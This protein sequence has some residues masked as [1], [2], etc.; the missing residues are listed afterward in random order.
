[1]SILDYYRD[2]RD[3]SED[4]LKGLTTKVNLLVVLRLLSFVSAITLIIVFW[5]F[6]LLSVLSGLIGVSL[7]G[8]F[9]KIH[10]K[11]KEEQLY[12]KALLSFYQ[13]ELKGEEEHDW[14]FSGDGMKYQ[15]P[16]HDFSNDID[17]FGQRSFFQRVNKTSLKGGESLLA[18]MMLANDPSKV[19]LFQ[20][21]NAE[22]RSKKVFL[23][24]FIGYGRIH[25]S[26]ISPELAKTWLSEYNRFIPNWI[27]V[28]LIIFPSIS[29][30]MIF[31]LATGYVSGT[32]FSAWLIFGLAIIG[33][34][35]KRISHFG[36][37]ISQ[38][39]STLKSYGKLLEIIE[40]EEFKSNLLVK[41]KSKIETEG[42][43]ASMII[44]SLS[45]R[46][47]LFNNR[48]NLLV[49]ILG[50]GLLLWDLQTS[51]RLEKW[52]DEHAK[53]VIEWIDTIYEFDALNSLAIYANNHDKY[54]YPKLDDSVNIS[55]SD[56][57]H[58]LIK[59]GQCVLNNIDISPSSFFIITGANMAGKST[60][61][62]TISLAILMTNLGLPVCASE[63]RIRPQKLITSM[64][65]SDS[66]LEDESYFFAELKRLK[67]IIDKIE[68]E[69]YFIILDEI[70]KGTN[71]KDKEE[72]SR[73]FVSRLVSLKATGIIATHDLGLCEIEKEHS[74][75][76]NFYFDAEIV[77]DELH[78]DYKMKNGVCKN[79]NAS[80]LLR[81]M[82][83]V[84]N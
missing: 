74:E 72:G 31:G 46:I 7:F 76:K 66:L 10:L 63:I 25:Q 12:W 64:R 32:I 39:A 18:S 53:E 30:L 34:F 16:N 71:S 38:I 22:L 35:V 60:F 79:M 26:D 82:K 45:R 50:N 4:T 75:V 5:K 51:F 68:K 48:N 2:R 55:A 81:K 77:D 19:K 36:N 24:K 44:N 14:S 6:P 67:F 84:S 9:I 11:T 20:E 17:L 54:Q 21:V 65:S 69:P 59:D 29:V 42:A 1:M 28:F 41:L 23:E 78:F 37:Q 52:I 33:M 47:D 70:L 15:I 8:W 56:L 27:K 57:G 43:N 62:R 73:K 40:K 83:I 13:N 80:F 3:A 61:L 58:P 49:A